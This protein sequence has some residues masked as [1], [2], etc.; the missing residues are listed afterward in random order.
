MNAF[1]ARGPLLIPG[2][3]AGLFDV[4]FEGNYADWRRQRH[5]LRTH[6]SR[7]RQPRRRRWH[8]RSRRQR[9]EA[10]AGRPLARSCAGRW[11][12][13]SPRRRRSSSAARRA[14]TGSKVSGP[15]RSRPTATCTCRSSNPMTVQRAQRVAQGSSGDRPARSRR[16]RRPGAA[17]RRGAL[18]SRQSAGRC[19]GDVKGFNPGG[20]AA[21]LQRRARFQAEGQRRTLSAATISMS[22]FSDL[23]GKL[24]GNTAS[25]SGHVLK[26]GEDWTFESVRLR[27]GTTSLAIDGNVGPTRTLESRFQHRRRQPGTAGRR[28]RAARCMRAAEL[29]ALRGTPVIRLDAQGAGIEHGDVQVDKLSAN[30]DVDWRGQRASHADIAISGL[31]FDERELTQFN[32]VLDGTTSAHTLQARRT[33]R[34]DQPAPRGQGRFQRRCLE[35]H[36]RGP[37]HRRRRQHQPASSTRRCR[38]HGERESFPARGPVPAR[39]GGATVRRR[40]L[41]RGRLERA[42]RRP[43][44]A[45]QHAHRRPDPARRI[46]GHHQCHCKPARQRAVR[47]SSAKRAPTWWT[48]PSATSSPADAPTSS[49][50]ARVSSR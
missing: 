9:P 47:R 20:A 3:G 13:A 15:M 44:P 36:D 45:D 6:A 41:E 30:V 32:A 21:R 7:H 50:S 40:R 12:R 46:P 1:H 39:Q 24:R 43:Q 29:R 23:S 49:A 25:G 34:Q 35:R 42:R 14:A 8:H 2:L 17:R 33:R 5:S 38:D 19:E 27:A 10:G 28:M 31:T 48:R 11:R 4:V 16:L 26:H 37:V 18:E 22:A